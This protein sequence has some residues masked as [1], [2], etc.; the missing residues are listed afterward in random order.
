MFKNKK[1]ILDRLG[2]RMNLLQKIK[3]YKYYLYIGEFTLLRR[4]YS[5]SRTFRNLI[6]GDYV[7]Q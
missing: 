1:E 5:N 4:F 3:G 6:I 2:L 7:Q